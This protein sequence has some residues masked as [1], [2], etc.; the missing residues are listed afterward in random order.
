M[1]TYHNS[2]MALP[3]IVVGSR[4]SL[5]ITRSEIVGGAGT[6]GIF[7]NG[8]KIIMKESLIRDHGI[9]GIL[10]CSRNPKNSTSTISIKNSQFTH[11]N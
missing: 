8:G 9:S 3:C 4:G 5:I 2:E 10:F 7:S 1:A 6:V 11:C